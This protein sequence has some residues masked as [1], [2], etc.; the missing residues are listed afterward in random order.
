MTAASDATIAEGPGNSLVPNPADIA[1]SL[2]DSTK[3]AHSKL[4]GGVEWYFEHWVDLFEEVKAEKQAALA[5]FSLDDVMAALP[6]ARVA[7]DVPGR[8][9]LRL[10]LLKGQQALCEMAADALNAVPGVDEVHVSSL[11]GSVLVM[12]DSDEIPSL[13]TLLDAVGA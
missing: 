7:S 8:A 9:R 6:G 10:P 2:A 4:L 13:Q 3:K 12:Y 1:S 5:S 11:T